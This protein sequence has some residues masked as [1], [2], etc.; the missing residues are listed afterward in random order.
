[1][2]TTE[3]TIRNHRLRR[4]PCSPHSPITPPI[5]KNPRNLCQTYRFNSVDKP[6]HLCYNGHYGRRSPRRAR[7]SASSASTAAL[8]SGAKYRPRTVVRFCPRWQ[9]SA[10]NRPR[11]VAPTKEKG[12]GGMIRTCMPSLSHSSH[13]APTD[14]LCPTARPVPSGSPHAGRGA[15]PKADRR[16]IDDDRGS[17]AGRCRSRRAEGRRR[18][19][20]S[21]RGYGRL[22]ARR[23]LSPDAAGRGAARVHQP[24]L[25][26]PPPSLNPWEKTRWGSGQQ[27][28]ERS[29]ER[30]VFHQ[31]SPLLRPSARSQRH[32]IKNRPCELLTRATAGAT[33]LEPAIFGLTGRHVKPLH[34]APST[35]RTI[36][37]LRPFV[38]SL[39]ALR[40]RP[41]LARDAQ[42][43][44]SIAPFLA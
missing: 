33:G 2:G 20:A 39:P 6:E 28:P 21:P 27:T 29:D 14:L 40:R 25:T 35:A 19:R 23:G 30:P 11:L 17:A 18:W 16:D 42:D 9:P 10:T 41:P 4:P 34:H 44:T 1:M 36:P 15:C 13:S 5:T 8:P 22:V 26:L 37:Q 12:H 7:T 32:Q 43:S 3:G 24:E 38:K 31:P